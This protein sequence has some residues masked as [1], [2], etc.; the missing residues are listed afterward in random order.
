LLIEPL[1]H[2]LVVQCGEHGAIDLVQHRR[3]VPCGAAR[4][5]NSRRRGRAGRPSTTLR[6]WIH[7]E[8]ILQS[9]P[10]PLTSGSL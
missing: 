10:G 4:P 3:G 1:L 6:R 8:H 7:M 2:G 5:T 9:A